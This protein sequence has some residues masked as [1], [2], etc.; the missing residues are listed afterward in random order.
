MPHDLMT[1]C[2]QRR[3][4]SLSGVREWRWKDVSVEEAVVAS[5]KEIRCVYCH[6]AVRI[7]KRRPGD[8]PQDHVEH[9]SRKDSEA[10]RGGHYFLG[11]HRMSLQ[12]VV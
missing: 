11:T 9:R 4:Y 5:E 2:A 6:G 1:R 10:C 8:D 7:R 3:L 12:P